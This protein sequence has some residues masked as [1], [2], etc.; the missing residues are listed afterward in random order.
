[1]AT[2]THETIACCTSITFDHQTT[3]GLSVSDVL[4]AFC[5]NQATCAGL[6][7]IQAHISRDMYL[8][9]GTLY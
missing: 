1:M 6:S 3:P 7:V 4:R 2:E 5:R 8:Y 9:R